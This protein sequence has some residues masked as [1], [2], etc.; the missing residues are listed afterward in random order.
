M[1]SR[2]AVTRYGLSMTR[3]TKGALRYA[4]T[5]LG[6]RR[7]EAAVNVGDGAAIR[8]IEALG[9]DFEGVMRRFGPGAQGDYALYA[10]LS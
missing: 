6:M 9:F 2:E 7:I 1:L 10:R 5:G 8:W 3:A 4:E